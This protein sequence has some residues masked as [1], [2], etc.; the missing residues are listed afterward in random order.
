MR[1]RS[2]WPAHSPLDIQGVV[3]HGSFYG[4]GSV[5]AAFYVARVDVQS[6]ARRI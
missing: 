3:M 1:P 4:S 6:L 2:V 5:L